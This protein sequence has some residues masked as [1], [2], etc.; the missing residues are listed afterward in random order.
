MQFHNNLELALARA[1]TGRDWSFYVKNIP[2]MLFTNPDIE[3]SRHWQQVSFP[4]TLVDASDKTVMEIVWV[5]SLEKGDLSGIPYFMLSVNRG[6][7]G[8]IS[9]DWPIGTCLE[10]RITAEMLRTIYEGWGVRKLLV[11]HGRR[12]TEMSAAVGEWTMSASEESVAVG[13][14][15]VTDIGGYNSVVVG[16]RSRTMEP[17]SV[18]IGSKA[19]AAGQNSVAINTTV[20]TDESLVVSA[21]PVM[22]RGWH[23]EDYEG[24]YG[25][26]KQ[27]G[28]V[29][30]E[31]YLA[32]NPVNIGVPP[33]LNPGQIITDLDVVAIQGAP[34]GVYYRM[35]IPYEI[36]W[37]VF[38]SGPSKSWP[39]RPDDYEND[40][41]GGYDFTYT[42]PQGFQVIPP[43]LGGRFGV[44]DNDREMTG[45]GIHSNECDVV[46]PYGV[47]AFVNELTFLCLTKNGVGADA[48]LTIKSWH[49]DGTEFTAVTGVT[50]AAQGAY[51]R[52]QIEL[53]ASIKEH[54]IRDRIRFEWT[55]A[56]YSCL[57]RFTARGMF[58][59][60]HDL[61]GG[62]QGLTND[63]LLG[64]YTYP[65]L[66]ATEE[67]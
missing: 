24:F 62:G 7:E 13:S 64:G 16:L 4:M 39:R 46:I 11:P 41:V 3:G 44:W 65:G 42:V 55:S 23:T 36:R 35:V 43:P 40:T 60:R 57:G 50:I 51:H 59:T 54:G 37:D 31:G 66:S 29:S 18:A 67:T 9:R 20:W 32:S 12:I 17:G 15:A 53:P 49:A 52:V 10:G 21:L 38:D 8:T 19:C 34:A 26:S 61:S 5:S 56:A 2:E 45:I 22:Q 6:S 48:Q 30:M 33:T 58:V 14:F 28:K 47:I 27:Q 1:A 25:D 63:R